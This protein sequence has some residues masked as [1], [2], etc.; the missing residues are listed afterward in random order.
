MKTD[1]LNWKDEYSVGLHTVDSQHK[2]FLGI[3]NELGDCI[4]GKQCI[5]NGHQFFFS[6]MH[7]AHEYLLKEKMLVTSVNDI[8]Y[9]FFREKHDEF[10]KKIEEFQREYQKGNAPSVFTDLYNYLKKLYP[11][12]LSYYT[13]SLVS[14]LK[15]NGIN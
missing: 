5:A 3:I 9:S 8:D 12:F 10:I 14:I 4:A 6:L 11:E 1:V 15:D 13:P 2:K 7:F